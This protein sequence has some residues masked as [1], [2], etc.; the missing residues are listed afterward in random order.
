MM[1]TRETTAGH[2]FAHDSKVLG[3]LIW[4][5]AVRPLEGK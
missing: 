3:T 5:A 1:L 4:P 2:D